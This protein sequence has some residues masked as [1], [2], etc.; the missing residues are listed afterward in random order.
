[1]ILFRTVILLGLVCLLNINIQ[2]SDNLV[3]MTEDW[4]PLNYV[5]NEELTGPAVDIVR[6]IQR[7]VNNTNKILV[8]PWKRAYAYTVEQKNKVLF[9]MVY[10]KKRDLLFKWVGPIAEKRYSLYANKSFKK[11]TGHESSKVIGKTPRIL[12]GVGTDKKVIKRLTVALKLGK[13]FEY[14]PAPLDSKK[15][16]DI[17]MVEKKNQIVFVGRDSYEKGI[18]ILRNIES[19]LNASVKYCTNLDWN[20]AMKT[21]KE[22]KILIVPSRTESIPQVIKEAFF[23]QVPVIA[24]NVG[25]IPELI[26]DGNTGLLVSPENPQ[27]MANTIN[28]L[29][30]D[31]ETQQKLSKN[32]FDFINKNFSWDVL[33]EEYIKL[34]QS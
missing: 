1:M 30:D 20:D 23:L 21:V 24:T 7:K 12:Q 6:E 18:D 15:F 13:K 10:S 25:G 27:E 11:L 19:K 9:S 32:A 16:Q 14:I 28:T 26:S 33:L 2:S 5:E 3:I 22:S 4:P 8:F 29:L 34:Y 17:P 31:D